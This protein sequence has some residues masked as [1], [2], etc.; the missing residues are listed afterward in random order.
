MIVL[1]EREIRGKG[2]MDDVEGFVMNQLKCENHRCSFFRSREYMAFRLAALYRGVEEGEKCVYYERL[3]LRLLGKSGELD[4]GS[5]VVNVMLTHD[6]V[7]D[8]SWDS[9]KKNKKRKKE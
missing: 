1:Y 3:C 8:D 2:D 6:M 5:K 7:F 4:K 9:E